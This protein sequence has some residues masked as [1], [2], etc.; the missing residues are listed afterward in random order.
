LAGQLPFSRV[1][2]LEPF[3]LSSL[4]YE[5]PQ[6]NSISKS[7]HYSGN[8]Q[9]AAS[10]FITFGL[11]IHLTLTL[12][13]IMGSFVARWRSHK[14]S[15]D[16]LE[17]RH[18]HNHHEHHDHDDNR[19]TQYRLSPYTPYVVAL[20]VLCLCIGAMLQVFAQYFAVLGLNTYG[21]PLPTD[22]VIG[23]SF[24]ATGWSLDIALTTYATVAWTTAL[25]SSAGIALVY[26]LPR[27]KK[28]V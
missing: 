4:L 17:S 6:S 3:Y 15:S 26:R 25:A 23:L 21:H 9:I 7:V 22:Q 1:Q 14:N 2:A 11:V 16:A 20:L 27:F 24:G 12:A 10:C 18:H 13:N 5:C 8:L 19:E 28:L